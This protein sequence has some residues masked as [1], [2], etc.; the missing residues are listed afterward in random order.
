MGSAPLDP[1]DAYR[2]RMALLAEEVGDRALLGS[3]YLQ[4]EVG[5]HTTVGAF[6]WDC[7]PSCALA[8]R[9]TS[10]LLTTGPIAP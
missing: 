8:P 5:G 1:V 3:S 7:A 6:S 4:R 2:R 9:A 10:L